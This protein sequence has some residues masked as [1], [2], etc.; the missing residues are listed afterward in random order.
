MSL[1]T[2]GA[3]FVVIFLLILNMHHSFCQVS[4]HAR[5]EMEW[6]SILKK[7]K[8]IQI[9]DFLLGIEQPSSHPD[10]DSFCITA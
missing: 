10:F 4:K 6:W 3:F 1:A 7:A 5:K 9:L 2:L 8:H